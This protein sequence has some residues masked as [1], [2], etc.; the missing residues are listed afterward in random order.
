MQSQAIM[1][2]QDDEMEVDYN[3]ERTSIK[4]LHKILEFWRK[5]HAD[6]VLD[7]RSVE[8]KILPSR[9]EDLAKIKLKA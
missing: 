2:P 8:S 9:Q 1:Q 4:L 7:H 6:L 3:G 5:N